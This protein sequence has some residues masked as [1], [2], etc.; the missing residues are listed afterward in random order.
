MTGNSRVRQEPYL[1]L[2]MEP[3]GLQELLGDHGTKMIL[4]T[5]NAGMKFTIF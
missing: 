5:F 1:P 3:L 4:I 2:Q